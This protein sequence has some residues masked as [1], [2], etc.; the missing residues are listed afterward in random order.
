[1]SFKEPEIV[2]EY[3]QLKVLTREWREVGECYKDKWSK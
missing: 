3:E 1:M 2:I